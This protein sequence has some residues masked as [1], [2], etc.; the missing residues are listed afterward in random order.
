STAGTKLK[1]TSGWYNGGNGTDS[2]GFSVLPAG[3]RHS[4]GSYAGYN[5]YF[6]S[7]SESSSDFAYYWY[8][9]YY[10]D[11]VDCDDNLKYRGFSVRCLKD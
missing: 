8:F 7:S 2:Y 9:T 11:N 1:S 10:D 3:L 4:G 5:A 6:C